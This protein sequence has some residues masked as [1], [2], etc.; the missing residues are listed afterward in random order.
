MSLLNEQEKGIPLVF[1][2]KLIKIETYLKKE[3]ET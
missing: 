1:L 3:C 2:I